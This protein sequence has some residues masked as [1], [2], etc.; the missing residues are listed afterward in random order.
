MA[1]KNM[2]DEEILAIRTI[3]VIPL[4]KLK[5]FLQQ[6]IGN[7][8]PDKIF[9]LRI[10]GGRHSVVTTETLQDVKRYLEEADNNVE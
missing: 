10:D 4:W 6:E 2:T 1:Y 5:V 3:S 7:L 9:Q 8:V